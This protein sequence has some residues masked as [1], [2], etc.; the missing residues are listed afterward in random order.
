MFWKL[1]SPR[2]KFQEIWYLLKVYFLGNLHFL[3]ISDSRGQ[4]QV[5]LGLFYGE[6]YAIHTV[7]TSM[8]PSPPMVRILAFDLGIWPPLVY[9]PNAS[10]KPRGS[11]ES[12]PQ[13][14]LLSR[15][16]NSKKLELKVEPGQMNAPLEFLNVQSLDFWS[17]NRHSFFCLGHA[18]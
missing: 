1:G 9:S 10:F 4:S 2:S 3:V 12:R 17:R 15:V 14:L 13:L 11:Q 6:T 7:F 16:C 8:N 5:F 18:D